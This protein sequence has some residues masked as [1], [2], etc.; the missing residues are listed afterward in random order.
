MELE[1]WIEIAIYSS[2]SGD[3]VLNELSKIIHIILKIVFSLVGCRFYSNRSDN[4]RGKKE[5]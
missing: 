2:D 5:F 3:F 4:L 1:K